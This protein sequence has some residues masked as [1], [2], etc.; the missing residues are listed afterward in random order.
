M[1]PSPGVHVD[2]P[3]EVLRR[4]YRP[5]YVAMTDFLWIDFLMIGE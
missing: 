5:D 3:A 2:Y 4:G 1:P